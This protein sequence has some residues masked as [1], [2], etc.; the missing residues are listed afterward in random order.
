MV[1]LE[2]GPRL[3]PAQARLALSSISARSGSLAA[4]NS[5]AAFLA[6]PALMAPCANGQFVAR[7]R[8]WEYALLHSTGANGPF[9]DRRRF[10]GVCIASHSPAPLA[11]SSIGAGSG[12]GGLKFGAIGISPI[13]DANGPFVDT[14]PVLGRGGRGRTA[15]SGIR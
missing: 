5:G 14:A 2:S 1:V 7:R 11:L 6:S 13:P 10:L 15:R 4:R 3:F 12:L 8:T 9:V